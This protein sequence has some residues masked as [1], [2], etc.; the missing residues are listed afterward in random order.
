MIFL[1]GNDNEPKC[2]ASK[3]LVE[4]FYKMEIDFIGHDV[5]KDDSMKEWLKHYANWPCFPQVYIQ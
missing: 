5:L 3:L 2:K 4:S 1:R